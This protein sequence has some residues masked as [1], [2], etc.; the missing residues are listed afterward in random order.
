MSNMIKSA[1]HQGVL[2]ATR[3]VVSSVEHVP[4]SAC[5]SE[6]KPVH[7]SV[8][9]KPVPVSDCTPPNHYICIHCLKI[10][11]LCQCDPEYEASLKQIDEEIHDYCTRHG[12]PLPSAQG[13]EG[14][15]Q[16]C[17]IL[18]LIEEERNP[19]PVVQQPPVLSALMN[20]GS[21]LTSVSAA[22]RDFN[23]ER[24]YA[25]TAADNKPFNSNEWAFQA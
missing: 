7:I 12:I 4:V 8:E 13:Y 2:V 20:L 22:P 9:A 15:V 21:T 19:K 1:N 11:M 16:T 25:P 5:S 6:A 14:H 23:D 3:T 17:A 18:D 24:A 10:D